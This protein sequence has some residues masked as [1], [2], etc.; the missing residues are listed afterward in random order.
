[1]H[2]Y[3]LLLYD[4]PADWEKISPDLVV[5]D[6]DG[7]PY[8]VRYEAV[9]VMLLNEFLKN[10]GKVEAQERKL[11]KQGA[12]IAQQ[13]NDFQVV[14][15]QQQKEIELLTAQL[16]EQARQMQKISGQLQMTERATKVVVNKP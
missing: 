12:M 15:A 10:H 13:R 14:S 1:M 11:E 6:P 5:H 3:M 9:N 8:T 7:K 16:K 4:N 2:K